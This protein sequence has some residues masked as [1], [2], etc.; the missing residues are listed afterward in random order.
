LQAYNVA[1]IQISKAE[2]LTPSKRYAIITDLDETALDNSG[3]AAWNYLNDTTANPGNLLVWQM[4]GKAKAVP[5]AKD[6]FNW[7]KSLN[8]VDIYYIS[9]RDI[10][11]RSVTMNNMDLLGFPN[12]KSGNEKY[13][14]FKTGVSSKEPR[15][16]TVAEDHTIILL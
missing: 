11:T 15:R 6:F 14:L 12:C 5:G 13:F 16:Q 10:S 1:R 2:K 7:V 8:N 3:S 4:M 9:N